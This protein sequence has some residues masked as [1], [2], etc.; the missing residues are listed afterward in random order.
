MARLLADENVNPKTA[1]GLRQLGHDVIT[2][3]ELGQRGIPDSEVMAIA[4]A[5]KRTVLTHDRRDFYAEH[6][7]QPNHSGI[8][9]CTRND[10]P[11]ELASQIH[12][13]LES[14]PNL[15]GQYATVTRLHS[16]EVKALNAERQQFP[17]KQITQQAPPSA[18]E[19][20][21]NLI[22]KYA[23]GTLHDS[24]GAKTPA[25]AIEASQQPKPSSPIAKYGGSSPPK[26]PAKTQNHNKNRER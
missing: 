10:N 8:I 2:V 14:Q 9:A 26:A 25:K 20:H 13:Q 21:K 22:T 19:Q 24:T 12:A 23:P 15:S 1:E 5:D 17:Q 16:S 6:K 4:M 7:K 18:S 11:K 3:S